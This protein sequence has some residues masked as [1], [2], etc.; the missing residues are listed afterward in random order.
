[1]LSTLPILDQFAL[2]NSA[3]TYA[4]IAVMADLEQKTGIQR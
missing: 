1:M 4:G 2:D 3:M